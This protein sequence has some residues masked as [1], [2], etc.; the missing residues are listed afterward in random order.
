MK[1]NRLCLLV[2]AAAI[3]GCAYAQDTTLN[4][5]V[6][7]ER[8]FQPV[9]QQAGKI[10]TKPQAVETTFPPAEV[11]YSDYV[12]SVSPDFNINPLLSQPT[13]F[14][15]PQ[16]YNG[17]VR[18][19]IGH[20]NTLFDFAYHLDDQ[21]NSI[22][23]VYANH[24]AEWG[25]RTNSRTQ[26]GF[27]FRHPFTT[28]ELY[29]GVR[30]ANRFYT[31]YGRY[32][33]G[34]KGLTIDHFKDFESVDKQTIWNVDAFVGVRSTKMSDIQYKA[35]VGYTLFAMPKE[36]SEHQLRTTANVDWHSNE[37]HVGGNFYMQNSF[38]QTSLYADSLYNSRHSLRIEP[39]YAYLGRRFSIH[40]GVQF[41]LNIGRGSYLSNLDNVTFAP[42]PKVD[43]E[44]QIAKKWLTLYGSATGSHSMGTVE[45]CMNAIPYR[46]V[47]PLITSH[48]AAP[49]TPIDAQLGFHIRPYRDLLIDIYGGYAYQINQ[50][51]T[52]ATVEKTTAIGA[53]N[54]PY[55]MLPGMI[56]YL[57]SDYGRG[58]IGAAFS[59]HYQDIITIHLGG[60]Y[61]FWQSFRF[62]DT[63]ASET[64]DTRVVLHKS[65]YDGVLLRKN[66]VYD[67]AKW[68]AHLR[69]DARIDRHW[70]LYSDNIFAG[71][72]TALVSQADADGSYE[73]KLKPTVQ[74]SLGCQYETV[75]GKNAHR[76]G[77]Q[78]N[79]AVFFQLNNYIHRHNDLWYGYQTE[80]INFVVGVTYRF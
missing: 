65:G 61:Y 26:V 37:H 44:A 42:A 48:H 4:R 53:G 30:G 6:T 14:S 73:R 31:R 24:R 59:Y 56:S 63:E 17:L 71:S 33:D 60:N 32:Y 77:Q 39:Y 18:G 25:R 45:A 50:L 40:A 10:A 12:A 75:V 79:L 35:Q 41:N 54:I 51:T 2:G 3:A 57:Y 36:V 11:H 52:I 46:N 62:E 19:G 34:D 28:A 20:T 22:L 80:G 38:L 16:T 69:I 29:F 23:D 76:A 9:V 58:K 78:P 8:D 74:L 43:F 67:R 1:M 27:D 72:R 47:H 55:E 70:T 21:K 13:R 15:T 5:N 7:V 49:Y 68:D 66:G 64:D